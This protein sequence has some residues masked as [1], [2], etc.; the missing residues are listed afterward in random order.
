MADTTSWAKYGLSGVEVG[1][2]SVDEHV[3]GKEVSE[4]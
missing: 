3:T 1:R 2:V 4:S